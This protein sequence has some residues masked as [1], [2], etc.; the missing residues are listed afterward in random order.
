VTP[1][2]DQLP[3]ALVTISG[4]GTVCHA[5]A[6]LLELLGLGPGALDGRALDA[7][8]TPAAA[9]LLQ[10]YLLPLLR[11]HGRVDEFRLDLRGPAGVALPTLA[12]GRVRS[13]EAGA[14]AGG[15]I[16]LTL[17]TIP[18]RCRL[19]DELVRI[20]QSAELAPVM[21]FQQ[22]VRADGSSYFRYATNVMRTLYGL[23]PQQVRESDAALFERVHPDDVGA[24]LGARSGAWSAGGRWQGRYRVRLPDGRLRTHELTATGRSASDGESHWHGVIADVTDP[25]ALVGAL[26][27][28]DAAEHASRTKSE[29]LARMSHEFRTP[30]NGI[31]GFA[32]LLTM[33]GALPLAEAQV[34]QL[35]LIER[36]GRSLLTLVNEVL[37]IARVESGTLELQSRAVGL[38]A[39]CAAALALSA[40]VA[41]TAQI[42]LDLRA[43]PEV[44]ATADPNR[45]RQ[46][47]SNLV[48]NAIKYGRRGGS[49]A[50]VCGVDAAGGYIE[51]HDD[52]IGLDAEQLA[53][54]F[55]PFQRVGAERLGI[56]GTGLGLVIARQL[57]EAM[58]GRIEVRSEVG[59]GSV[60]TVRLPLDAA[61][62]L[63][64]SPRT[65]SG[66]AAAR[67]AEEEGRVVL[68]VEDNE[69]NRRLMEAIFAQRPS[70]RLDTVTDGQQ[71]IA[72]AVRHG[73]PDLLML[74][75]HLPDTSGVTLLGRLR[76]IPGWAEVRAVAV[77]A[78]AMREG[79]ALA[80][81]AGFEA[82][83]TKPLDVAALCGSLDALLTSG[84]AATAAG[85]EASHPPSSQARKP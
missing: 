55:V 29:F 44:V 79:M 18:E 83:W 74:D 23:T 59:V 77:S 36:S 19:E 20:R 73:P 11:L 13:A 48:S 66:P 22:I 43:G 57:T 46:V 60:F 32:Q 50:L 21:L 65:P 38:R 67:S 27:D 49:V 26:K 35:R 78:D 68:H 34:Q 52:G 5:N 7:V 30:L 39:Q 53:Q 75:I 16:D 62:D 85:R 54:L 37:D 4:D 1:S 3:T 2:L 31:I 70:W 6:R 25:E 69:V 15:L 51:V 42:T 56:E 80:L 41:A 61:G 45:L 8:L 17:V 33:P 12:Y 72:Y 14:E 82:Y 47:L 64:T 81:G 10:S 71:A 58:A 63:G 9:V 76:A 24:L 28:K 40:P 84:R